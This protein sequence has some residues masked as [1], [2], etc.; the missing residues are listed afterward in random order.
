[1]LAKFTKDSDEGA[2]GSPH[3]LLAFSLTSARKPPVKAGTS[4]STPD[5]EAM[6][7]IVAVP[8]GMRDMGSW[9]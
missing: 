2:T 3:I 9:T 8:R 7:V 5:P 4:W 6:N 1:M